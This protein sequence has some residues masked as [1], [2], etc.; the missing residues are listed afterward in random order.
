MFSVH[1]ALRILAA[2]AKTGTRSCSRAAA[3]AARV[4]R[5]VAL[6]GVV[7]VTACAAPDAHLTQ[8]RQGAWFEDA[9]F[10]PP[11]AP[12]PTRAS[13][14]ALSAP[15]EAYARDHLQ[16]PTAGRD[17]RRELITA[18]YEKA[19]LRIDYEASVTRDAALTFGTRSGNCLSLVIMTAAF[20]QHLG[21]PVSY[22]AVLLDDFHSL[23]GD[24]QFVS[25]HVN[26]VLGPRAARTLR[27]LGEP[28]SLVVDF[29][30]QIELRGVRT[31][32]LTESTI[33]AM[34]FNNRAAELLAEGQVSMAYWAARR[35]LEEDPSFLAALN[36]LGVIYTRHRLPAAA[37]RAFRH[38]LRQDSQSISALTN[39]HRL[40]VGQGRSAE[41]APF[42]AQLAQLQPVTPFDQLRRGQA[43]MREARYAQAR[44]LFVRELRLQPFQDE[45]HFWAAQAY[46]LLGERAA[47]ERHLQYAHDFSRT[48]SAQQRYGAKLE[49]LRAQ[50]QTSRLQ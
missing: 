10:P 21:I 9:A 18:L 26:L 45:V 19:R 15:M 41:A 23:S 47:A 2:A 25:G 42:E 12:L 20:A 3:A 11:A 38:V 16:A 50:L 4:M 27:D 29:L 1:Q 6:L 35:A 32:A 28:D 39:L 30:P 36:T 34:Y 46:W 48:R 17:T 37:E 43:A 24:L 8:A 44:D 22:Q 33:V 40:L 14:F 31:K 5:S 13:L 49:H 7:F